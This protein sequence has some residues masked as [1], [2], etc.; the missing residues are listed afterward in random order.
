MN[1]RSYSSPAGVS[2]HEVPTESDWEEQD[3]IGSERWR[4]AK[5]GEL[6]RQREAGK[7]RGRTEQYLRQPRLAKACS[8]RNRSRIARGRQTTRDRLVDEELLD[9]G[10]ESAD[11]LGRRRHTERDAG[12]SERLERCER[13]ELLCERAGVY[14]SVW[15]ERNRITPVTQETNLHPSISGQTVRALSARGRRSPRL[16]STRPCCTVLRSVARCR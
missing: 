12:D 14:A 2:G 3:L 8:C 6:A 5:A 1:S 9:K 4:K 13:C 10:D 15:N 11:I 7:R 16:C